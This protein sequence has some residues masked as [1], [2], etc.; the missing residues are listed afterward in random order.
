MQAALAV[1]VHMK[2]YIADTE[3]K[4][5]GAPQFPEAA[6]ATGKKV[7][8]IGAGPAGMAAAYYL[9][10]AGHKVTVFE[11]HAKSGG[12]LR[13]GIPYYRLPDSVLADEFGAI[14]KR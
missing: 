11:S 6:P 5:K 14:E 9:A 4:A 13:Y 8:I 3:K 1:S 12:M 7:A 10:L 2:R